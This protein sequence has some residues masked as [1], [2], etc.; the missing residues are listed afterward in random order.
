MKRQRQRLAEGTDYLTH[1]EEG[2]DT[3]DGGRMVT[4]CFR[5][6]ASVPLGGGVDCGCVI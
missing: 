3:E 4:L 5:T 2:C 6:R 1:W